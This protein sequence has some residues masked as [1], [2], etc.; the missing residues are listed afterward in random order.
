MSKV[1]ETETA[2]K[3]ACVTLGST[4]SLAHSAAEHVNAVAGVKNWEMVGAL[5]KIAGNPPKAYLDRQGVLNQLAGTKGW[6]EAGAAS[7]WAGLI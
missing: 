1:T 5:N 2:I 7:R 6:G 4:L 3:T